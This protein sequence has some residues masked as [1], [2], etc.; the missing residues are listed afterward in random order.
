MT[1]FIRI[2][3]HVYED[4]LARVWV[5]CAQ[6]IG[7]R[8]ERTAEAY[9]STDGRGI[10][11][12]GAD[13]MLDP[14]DSLAQ[15]ILHELCHALVEG[16]A[17]EGQTDWGL[18]NTSGRH[19][20]REHATLR[21]QAY[22]TMPYGLRDFFAPT[23]DFR[24]K[25]WDEL[26]ADPYAAPA[27]KGGRRERSCVAARLA[28]WRAGQP[29]W[30]GPLREALEASAAIAAVTPRSRE[31]IAASAQGGGSL[32]SLWHTVTHP[33]P[34]HPAGH[35]VAAHYFGGHGCAD[36]AW[37]FSARGGLRCRHAPAARLP[38]DAPPCARWEPAEELDCQTCGACCREAYHS[39]E[40]GPGEKVVKRHP[41]LVL[42]LETHTKLRREGERCAALQGGQT[43]HEPYACDIYPDRPRTCREF[44][45]GSAHCLD[46]RSRVGLSL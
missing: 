38:G 40:V 17:G 29:R 36:C 34:T 22:L 26:P 31:P 12:I 5:V 7:F 39:V 1:N 4:P 37:G 28:A 43:P 8:V 32:P 41:D 23:T 9:A 24:V 14:D 16:E 20:W 25:F 19:T 46:A 21:L 27:E 33:L 18:D 2:P 6:R 3:Q 30:A 10:L 42:K 35:A 44:A 15:M 45:R 13:E 11:L